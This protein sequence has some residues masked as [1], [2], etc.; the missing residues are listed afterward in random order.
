LRALRWFAVAGAAGVV[1]T[2]VV[3]TVVIAHGRATDRWMA[4]GLPAVATIADRDDTDFKV[5]VDVAIAG[6][7]AAARRM[8]APVDLPE[9]YEEGRRYPA[10]V[11]ADFA[12]VRL[13]AEPYD[14][15]E[16]ILWFAIPTA[17]LLWHLVRRMLGG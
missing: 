3:A 2:L 14:R 10:V 1:I 15:T 16:P 4:T 5:A 12:H 11:S 7:P 9:E 13:L 17:I 6:E 8:M